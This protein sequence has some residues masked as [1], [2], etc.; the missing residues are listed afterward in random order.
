M[1]IDD[2][3][4]ITVIGGLAAIISG[5]AGKAF[6]YLKGR[7]DTCEKDREELHTQIGTLTAYIAELCGRFG[8]AFEPGDPTKTPQHSGDSRKVFKLFRDIQREI[9]RKEEPK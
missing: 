3:T 4:I 5:L 8:V 6:V 2:S 9:E 1:M 7:A